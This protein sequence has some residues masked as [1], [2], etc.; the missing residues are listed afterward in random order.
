MQAKLSRHCFIIAEAGVNH[1]GSLEMARELIS[2]AAEAGAD[3]VKFQSFSTDRLVTAKAQKAEYQKTN[4]GATDGQAEMLRALE[5]G[6]EETMALKEHCDSCDITFMSTPFDP[7]IMQFLVD[8]V[9]VSHIKIPSGEAIN[10]LLLLAAARSKRPIILSSGMCTMSEVLEALATLAWG[11]THADGHP[12]G[13]AELE[14]LQNTPDWMDPLRDHVW[15]LHCVSEY[16]APP[17]I[18]NLRAMDT[19]AK[20]TGL[21]VGLSDHSAGRHIALAAVARGAVALEKHFTLSRRLP[22]PDH[23]ASL[24]PDELSSLIHEIRDVEAA[25]GDGEKVPQ[26][27]ELAN[28]AVARGSLVAATPI[29]AGDAFTYNNLTIKRPASGLSPQLYW[30]YISGMTARRNYSVDDLID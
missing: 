3:A 11:M 5:L 21:P 14:E 27:V 8:D 15:L 19:M 10:G 9:G 25:L 6:R 13:R 1:N 17:E 28:R 2:A 12:S 23:M 26:P 29:K 24:E 4:T 20:L 7:D 22:G 30:D 16:P 18:T